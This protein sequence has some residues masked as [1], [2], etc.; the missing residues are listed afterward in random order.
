MNENVYIRILCHSRNIFFTL[1]LFFLAFPFGFPNFCRLFWDT[2]ALLFSINHAT[3]KN[4]TDILPT[5]H[6]Y[7]E[8]KQIFHLFFCCSVINVIQQLCRATLRCAPFTTEY[9]LKMMWMKTRKRYFFPT[10]SVSL[11]SVC[12]LSA[13]LVTNCTRE[14]KS[15]AQPR[16]PR[17][18]TI[19]KRPVAHWLCS[20]IFAS[21]RKC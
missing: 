11:S 8:K 14:A 17:E 10:P 15:K 21:L 1:L 19:T 20:W 12:A 7:C 18:M 4:P 3:V 9:S 2:F 16:A 6:L 5:F 13:V